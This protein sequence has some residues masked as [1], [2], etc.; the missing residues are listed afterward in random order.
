MDINDILRKHFG[1]DAD[2]KELYWGGLR[3]TTENGEI[4]FQYD[5]FEN[6]VGG[7]EMY[8]AMVLCTEE[9]WGGVS[10]FG[11][12]NHITAAMAHGEAL[13]IKVIP[14]VRAENEGVSTFWTC[15]PLFT[16]L[17]WAASFFLSGWQMWA[18]AI[19]AT[20][21]IG[22]GVI[23]PAFVKAG[24]RD[25]RIRGQEYQNVF[26]DMHGSDRRARE[27]DARRRGVI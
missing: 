6:L 12:S 24:R 23:F 20:V 11:T 27:E 14:E 10:V 8:Q 19:L 9:L 25:A 2:I 5:R 4:D 21:F 3:I 1:E 17:A 26:P 16:A 7:P 18:A 22:A 15:V 13:G